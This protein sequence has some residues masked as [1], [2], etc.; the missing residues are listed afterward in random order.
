M[1]RILSLTSQLKRNVSDTFGD[2]PL[3][4]AMKVAPPSH[5]TADISSI[6]RLALSE[7]AGDRGDVTCEA[8][9]PP[10]ILA[11][12]TFLAKA[13]GVLAG[14]AVAEMVFLEVDKDLKVQWTL[15]DGDIVTKGKEFGK[16]RGR[17]R[18]I[19]VGERVALNFMQRM[20]GIATATKKMAEAAKP[21]RILETRKTV[22]GLRLLDK[23][24]VLIGG[25]ENHR[26][27][28][29][30]M[31]MIKDNHIAA[32]G[33]IPQAVAATQKY[34]QDRELD[35]GVEVETRTLDEVKEL[36]ECRGEGRGR[37]TRIMLDNMVAPSPNGGLDVSMLEKAVHL[38]GGQL[39]TEAS[40]NLTME[41]VAQIGSTG[42][43]FIS[44]GA[45]THSVKALDISLNIDNELALAV[46]KR[47]H[48]S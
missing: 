19:L 43:T 20:S 32:A 44:S 11:E 8:T 36:L 17:A 25:G 3:E 30:D 5:P 29:F 15:E 14:T 10:E 9:I 4:G 27:G 22:P 41:T 1:H 35:M 33:G 28:L 6:V 2:I 24:A 48:R 40:G 21:A 23:W 16:V 37:V 46:G 13:D 7:D 34:L 42:V 45:L 18:S 47:T 38:V 12:A 39:E 26:M 31:V